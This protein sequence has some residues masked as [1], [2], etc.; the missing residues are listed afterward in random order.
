M[1]ATRDDR[2]F[3]KCNECPIRMDVAPAAMPEDHIR[4]PSGWMNLGD[5][6]HVCPQCAPRWM[7][8]LR[9]RPG[10]ATRTHRRF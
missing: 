5:N 7:Q 9:A 2:W 4:M 1:L 3:L 6:A 8:T 10:L